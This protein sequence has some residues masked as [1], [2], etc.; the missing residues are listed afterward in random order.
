[1]GVGA[2]KMNKY[3]KSNSLPRD[4]VLNRLFWIVSDASLSDESIDSQYR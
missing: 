2:F 3:R 4:M 1:M